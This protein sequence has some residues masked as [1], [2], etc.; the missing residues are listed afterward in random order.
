MP[1]HNIIVIGAGGHAKV[2]IDI[3]QLNNENVLAATDTDK[4][5]HGSNILSVPIVGSDD[6]VFDYQ[7][8]DIRLVIGI[9]MV[10]PSTLRKKIYDKFSS[11]GYQ[12]HTVIHP[13]CTV[14]RNA[15]IEEGCQLL[16]NSFIGVDSTIRK[17]AIV[18]SSASIDHDC[19][20]GAFSHIAPGCVLCGHVSVG[21]YT[22]IGAGATLT[23]C[24]HVESM[25]FIK[26]ASLCIKNKTKLMEGI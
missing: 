12:F 7:P 21:E 16:A 22:M 23:P 1:K 6:V 14:S 15:V 9:G 2:L 19:D 18:N 10:A 3:L 4:S 26:A 25:G 20:I 11:R 5:L 17:Q 8:T 24:S 13:A